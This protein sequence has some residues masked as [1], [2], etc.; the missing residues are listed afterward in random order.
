[1]LLTPQHFCSFVSLDS[2]HHMTMFHEI[3]VLC[4]SPRTR[5]AF[6]KWSIILT[7]LRCRDVGDTDSVKCIQKIAFKMAISS[8]P[9]HE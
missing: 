9:G 2:L 6:V 8:I 7:C 4:L 3:H 5:T 1:M